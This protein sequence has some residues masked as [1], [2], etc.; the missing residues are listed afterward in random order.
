MKIAW[1]PSIGDGKPAPVPPNGCPRCGLEGH[2]EHLMQT[3]GVGFYRCA[4]CGH[5]FILRTAPVEA[6]R[7]A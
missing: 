6:A 2:R 4:A 5:M 3:N 1:E 7:S